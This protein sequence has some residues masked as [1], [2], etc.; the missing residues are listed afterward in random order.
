MSIPLF[1][2]PIISLLALIFSMLIA[3]QSNAQSYV[4]DGIVKDAT[5]G[6]VLVAATVSVCDILTSTNISGDFRVVVNQNTCNLEVR[7]LGY[8]SFYETILLPIEDGKEFIVFL[9]PSS[10]IL[11][12]AVITANKFTERQAESTVSLEILKPQLF[13]NTNAAS[14]DDALDFVPGVDIIDGQANIRGGSGYSY[15][16]GSRVLLVIDNMPALQFDGG[17]SNWVDIPTENISQVEVLKGA[18]SVLYGSAALNGV[19]NFTTNNPS[20]NP[21]TKAGVSYRY[22]F[23]PDDIKRQ[24]W[25]SAPFET[26]AYLSHSRKTGKWDVTAGGFFNI[27][28]SYNQEVEENRGRAYAKIRY[29]IS[30]K[31]TFTLNSNLSVG[32]N[33]NFFYWGNA[34]RKSFQPGDN[35]VSK[36]EI[37]RFFID[38]SVTFYDRNEDKHVVKARF[39]SANNNNSNNQAVISK[40]QYL[41]YTYQKNLDNFNAKILSGTEGVANQTEAELYSNS[42]YTG[43]NAAVFLQWNQQLFEKLNYVLGARYEYNALNN[44]AFAY[45]LR[46][47]L[48]QVSANTEAEAKPVFRAGLNYNLVKGTYIRASIGQ[49]YRYPTIAE[50]F[51]FANAG[52]LT[53]VPN[54]NLNSETGWS[55]E[56]G[57]RQEMK[58]KF[59]GAYIDIAAFYSRYDN[60]MEF[61]LSDQVFAGFQ[62]RNIGN[63][64]ISGIEN[65]LGFQSEIGDLTIQGLISYTYINPIY[66]NFDEQIR[67]SATTDENILKYRYRHSFKSNL[68]ISLRNWSLWFNQRYNSHMISIDKNFEQFIS[69]IA[70][71]RNNFNQGYN[72]LGMQL[73]YKYKWWNVSINL[74]NATNVLYTERPALL[75]APRN[76]SIRWEADISK[77]NNE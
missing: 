25:T 42:S 46:D 51:T 61:T 16:A 10:N 57:I 52:G 24:W 69:G 54:P 31:T 37:S 58:N 68:S 33:S 19:I 2:I 36:S 8:E 59:I 17:Y 49:G 56:I 75:E 13:K 74:D 63:T 12:Q 48:Y 66:R 28:R 40:F 53:I 41:N 34:L 38:P 39:Y 4:L 44:P 50:K 71:F 27:L 22:F 35:T 45:D 18:S 15:G 23:P 26:N 64:A 14:V 47:S 6:E 11:N 65:A 43:Y 32:D 20:K 62:A 1:N 9:S 30:P 77:S 67:L 55:S 3:I 60:M 72:V 21:R 5:T 70:D 73:S 29:R 7:Y 76:I